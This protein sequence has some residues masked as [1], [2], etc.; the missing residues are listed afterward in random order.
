MQ[1]EIKPGLTIEVTYVTQNMVTRFAELFGKA[2]TGALSRGEHLEITELLLVATQDEISDL[3]KVTTQRFPDGS[4]IISGKPLYLD[5]YGMQQFL[6]ALSQ[7]WAIQSGEEIRKL[8]NYLREDMTGDEK[9]VIDKKVAEI[10]ALSAETKRRVK[11]QNR[12]IIQHLI[13]ADFAL[14]LDEEVPP[15]AAISPTP[16]SPTEEERKQFAELAKKMGYRQQP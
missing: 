9:K 3:V 13:Q 7:Q 6:Y 16:E 14:E 5:L 1:A 11:A 10:Q 4:E 2:A 15:T 12:E 8:S